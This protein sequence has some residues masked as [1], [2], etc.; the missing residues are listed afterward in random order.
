MMDGV[1]IPRPSTFISSSV[2]LKGYAF[3]LNASLDPRLLASDG[4]EWMIPRRRC[5]K[6]NLGIWQQWHLVMSP[7]LKSKMLSWWARWKSTRSVRRK[8]KSTI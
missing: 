2:E 8:S 7:P 5:C 4:G 3:I 6:A 1:P